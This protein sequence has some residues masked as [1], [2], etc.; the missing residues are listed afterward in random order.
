MNIEY[1]N[2]LPEV[3]NIYN[4]DQVRIFFCHS[5]GRNPV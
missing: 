3:E 2:S 4:V 1:L 5:E